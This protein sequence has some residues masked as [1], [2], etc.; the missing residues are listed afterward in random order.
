[1]GCLDKGME[2]STQKLL[3][4]NIKKRKIHRNRKESLI[5]FWQMRVVQQG[6]CQA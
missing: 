4:E 3:I 2:K 1:M 5:S 6:V